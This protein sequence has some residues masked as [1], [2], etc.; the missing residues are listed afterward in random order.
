MGVIYSKGEP[1][2]KV[3]TEDLVDTLFEEIDRYYDAGKVVV[4]DE[5]AAAEGAALLAEIEAATAGELTPERLAAMEK[6]KQ[7]EEADAMDAALLDE[8]ESPVDGR[9][10]TRA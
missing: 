7:A 10:F 9:R 4:R 2:R 3:R 6:A 8:A 1:L 5:D